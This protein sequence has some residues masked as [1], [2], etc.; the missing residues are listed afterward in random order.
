MEGRKIKHNTF[1]QTRERRAGYWKK[2]GITLI[3]L[4]LFTT[5]IP[6]LMLLMRASM[7][8][9]LM[10]YTVENQDFYIYIYNDHGCHKECT[11]CVKCVT[12]QANDKTHGRKY[13]NALVEDGKAFAGIL[14]VFIWVFFGQVII[15]LAG[16]LML[17]TLLFSRILMNWWMSIYLVRRNGLFKSNKNDDQHNQEYVDK[18]VDDQKHD[19]HS[20]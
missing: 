16:D 8:T 12:K 7:T 2:K 10:P 13:D 9:T 1:P 17:Q 3:I 14:Q 6:L 5:D 18:E 11:C 19:L 4:F 15:W 20:W